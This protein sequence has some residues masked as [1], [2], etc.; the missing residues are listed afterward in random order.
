VVKA[1]RTWSFSHARHNPPIKGTEQQLLVLRRAASNSTGVLRLA[2][3]V[4]A[5]TY[6][7]GERVGEPQP[8]VVF[9]RVLILCDCCP[10]R[11]SDLDNVVSPVPTFAFHVQE[12]SSPRVVVLR[13][14]RKAGLVVGDLVSLTQAG[15]TKPVQGLLYS[16]ELHGPQEPRSRATL[17]V[18]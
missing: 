18:K 8:L 12:T 9:S 14:N 7:C 2:W 15:V 11:L 4:L 10:F 5:A 3:Q 1:E 6:P 17:L 16:S 13:W